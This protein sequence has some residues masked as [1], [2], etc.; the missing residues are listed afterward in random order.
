[1]RS[2]LVWVGILGGVI[3][4]FSQSTPSRSFG[5]T[6][7][8]TA[9]LEKEAEDALPATVDVVGS[10]E[11]EARQST[12][13]LDLLATLPSMS[14]VRSGSPGQVTSLFTRGTESNHTLALWNGI[15]LNDPY[16]GGFNWGFLATDGVDRIEVVR[17]PF[18]SLYGG[19]ALGGV[20]QVLSAR[21]QGVQLNLEAGENSY[22]RAGLAAGT[23]IGSVQIDVAGHLRRGDGQVENDDYQGDEIMVRADWSLRPGMSIGLALRGL[24]AD[25][26]IAYSG[27]SPSPRRRISWQEKLVGLPFRFEGGS[28]RVDAQLSGIFY[29][30]TFRDPED[31]FGFTASDTESQV[32]RARAV[33]SYRLR[34]PGSWVAFGGEAD[35]SEVTDSSVFGTN[36]DGEGQRNWAVFSELYYRVGDFNFD[37][38]LRHDENNVYG[39]QTSPRLGVQWLA[40]ERARLWASYGEAF[41]APAVGELYFPISGNPDLLPE[42]SRSVELGAEY[43]L[44]S[45]RFSL[46]GYDNDLSNLIDFDFVEFKNINIGRARTRGAEAAVAYAENRWAARWNAAY[47]DAKDLDTDEPLL[48]RPRESSNLVVSYAPVTWSVTLTGRYVG[49]RDD[50]DPVSFARTTNDSYIRFDLAGRWQ[51]MKALAPYLRV[52]NFT[53]E[54][55]QEALGFPAPGITLVGGIS[56]SYR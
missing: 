50:I 42:I 28:W 7:V 3:P 10:K 27:G 24:N 18:S 31:F 6:I 52:E 40:T 44:S 25:T 22:A 49:E 41:A 53:D 2:V 17:G 12:A 33:A 20:V 1:M 26:G 15:E 56:L 39:G 51:A 4:A 11:I 55:Y 45:W 48:R 8:V 46:V 21:Q 36:L 38:G 5:D 29:D 37:L 14:V 23:N 13:V 30:S 19:D 16:F 54:D 43:L 35:E 34:K 47:L 32:A 9:S